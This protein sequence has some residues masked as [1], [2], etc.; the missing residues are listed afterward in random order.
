MKVFTGCAN[1]PSPS[2]PH[3]HNAKV[4]TAYNWLEHLHHVDFTFFPLP[5]FRLSCMWFVSPDS[6]SCSSVAPSQRFKR[7]LLNQLRTMCFNI[8]SMPA[9]IA[10]PLSAARRRPGVDKR[11]SSANIPA[12]ELHM[13][14]QQ[15]WHLSPMWRHLRVS[16]V[17]GRWVF[18]A[19]ACKCVEMWLVPS[20]IQPDTHSPPNTVADLSDSISYA[21]CFTPS[22]LEHDAR[23]RCPFRQVQTGVRMF[24]Q[25]DQ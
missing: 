5:V 1:V 18:L 23:L 6:Q 17:L 11:V 4:P 2:P 19:L 22:A 10:V 14:S 3:F 20:S 21:Y 24:D 15:G 12:S 16:Q 9:S 7:A 13:S 25:F 8:E